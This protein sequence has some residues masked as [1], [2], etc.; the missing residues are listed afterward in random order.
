MGDTLWFCLD[1]FEQAALIFRDYTSA[2]PRTN[3]AAEDVTYSSH[4]A[5]KIAF[6]WSEF[7]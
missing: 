2:V 3:P 1:W 7:F 4:D 6:L 5:M